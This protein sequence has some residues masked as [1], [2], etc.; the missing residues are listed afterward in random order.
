MPHGIKF[1]KLSLI[2]QILTDGQLR[3]YQLKQ[4][5][6]YDIISARIGAAALREKHQFVTM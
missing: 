1:A 6:S 5:L 2:L 4:I 3:Y